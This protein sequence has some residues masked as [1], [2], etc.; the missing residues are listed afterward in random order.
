MAKGTRRTIGAG[1]ETASP[2]VGLNEL[3]NSLEQNKQAGES[4]DIDLMEAP[5]VENT[6]GAE[7]P[8]T[9]EPKTPVVS[10]AS[11][12]EGFTGGI[13]V[14]A[15]NAA[16]KHPTLVLKKIPKGNFR[17]GL[18]RQEDAPQLMPGAIH[19]FEPFMQG[20]SYLTAL[21]TDDKKRER[22]EKILM[23][24]LRPTSEY[25]A[26]ITYQMYD[27]P[28]GQFMVFDNS[29]NGAYEEVV[30]NC[31]I[32]SPLVANGLHEYTSGK[33]PLAEWY[34]ENKEAE[35]II[36]SNKVD[37]ELKMFNTLATMPLSRM[38]EI[39]KIMRLPDAHTG[40]PTLVKTELF[41]VLKTGNKLISSKDAVQK[42]LVISNWDPQKIVVSTLVEDAENLNIIRQSKTKD[43]MYADQ[44]LGAS[45][46]EAVQFLMQPK[47]SQ[48]RESIM[49]KVTLMSK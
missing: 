44:V 8:K 49:N 2:V 29:V 27:R 5:I 26:T 18:E 3:Q 23:V 38:V 31:M 28:H 4:N 37:V 12:L 13:S 34:I 40:S 7:A 42:F 45:K 20:N 48:I 33:K 32:A 21:A 11:I 1:I 17:L 43:W 30:Y 10:A 46:E 19:K 41:K 6:S 22:L 16:L 14:G 47:A 25:Y 9:A 35:A 36:E 39:A 24:D 15:E